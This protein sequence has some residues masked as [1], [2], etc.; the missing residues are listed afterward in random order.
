[1]RASMHLDPRG[2]GALELRFDQF[3]D[4]LH[5]A[6]EERIAG[7]MDTLW[8]RIETVVPHRT[9]LLA[10]EIGAR[11]FADQPDRIAGYV[12]VRGAA[13]AHEY[14]KAGALEYGWWARRLEGGI[15]QR[16]YGNNRRM[17]ARME[18]ATHINAFRYLRGPFE[19]MRPEIE[20]ALEETIAEQAAL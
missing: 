4:E 1:M 18:G 7:L 11:T 13:D 20:A 12:S 15:M 10:S 9:G 5:G 19:E 8:G 17:K 3:P 14:E 2:V 6:L 16:I